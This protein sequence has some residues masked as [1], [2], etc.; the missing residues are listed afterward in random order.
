MSLGSGADG[1]EKI[2]EAFL[3]QRGD[4]IKAGAGGR[5]PGRKELLPWGCVGWLMIH[6]GVGGCQEKGGFKSIF[7]C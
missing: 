4:F 7:I 6:L 2:L 5:T 3:V 1:Q